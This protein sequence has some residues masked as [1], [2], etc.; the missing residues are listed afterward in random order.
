MPVLHNLVRVAGALSACAVLATAPAAAAPSGPAGDS[1]TKPIADADGTTDASVVI[2]ALARAGETAAPSDWFTAYGETLGGLRTL[3]V[4][5]FLYPTA[6]PFCLGSTA[7]GIAPAVAGTIPG[8]WPRYTVSVPGLDLSAVKSGQ[9]MFAFVPYGL[10][11]DG[12]DTAGMQVAWL[13]LTNGKSGLTP[14]GPLN[15]VLSGMIPPAVPNELRPVVERAVHDYF[16]S[17]LPQG[18]VRAVPVDTGS[19]TV[20][21]AMFGIV[22]NGATSCFFFP[23]VGLTPV[24]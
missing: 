2:A 15:Q 10:N 16:A 20:L 4:D 5:P 6:A 24:P 11:P 19:G 21:A 1:A 23:T 13:N 14:M 7:L 9:A 17:A 22:R 18:G 12:A 3:G 8:P